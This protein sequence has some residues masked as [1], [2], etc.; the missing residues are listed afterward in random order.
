MVPAKLMGEG[1]RS[2]LKVF[3]NNFAKLSLVRTLALLFAGVIV[4]VL[5]IAVI[6]TD[7]IQTESI[8]DIAFNESERASEM[9]FQTLYSAMKRGA[10]RYELLEIVK[11]LN[12]II[13]TMETKLWRTN[14]IDKQFGPI[15]GISL[16]TLKAPDP[17]LLEIS[18]TAKEKLI[19]EEDKM[20]FL[21][22]LIVRKE[23]QSCHS[24]ASVGAVN[25]IID[26]RI[27]TAVLQRPMDRAIWTTAGLFCALMI[28]IFA[29]LYLALKYLVI[30]P[31]ARLTQQMEAALEI[32]RQ[33]KELEAFKSPL[34][35]LQ[36]MADAFQGLMTRVE[37]SHAALLLQ[38]HEDPLTGLANRRRLDSVLDLEI[39]RSERH[40]H[41][42]GL[43]M[44]D[45]DSFKPINDSFGHAA[46]D[47]V[48]HEVARTLQV[49]SRTTDLPA[50]LG[51]DEFMILVP[52]V[53][54]DEGAII[55]EKFSTLLNNMTVHYGDQ[56]I[57][58]L[59]SVGFVHY[60][61]H[62]ISAGE[63]YRV[64]DQRMYET[65]AKR[66]KSKKAADRET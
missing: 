66:K 7:Y 58:V 24:E 9:I 54:L 46:G 17:A 33:P 30:R 19:H 32:G 29:A 38:S 51:G 14:I 28:L 40:G 45:L 25:G 13:P 39:A 11:S 31:T 23:C 4:F 16:S 18:K 36:V 15:D 8:D 57:F 20:R 59:A 35:E 34:Y 49:N 5:V 52:E 50:R 60:P 37:E 10:S 48:L 64:A 47:E 12:G 22:P 44:I 56:A 65:K 1:D 6:I 3:R 53:S 21:Y 62:A 26:I 43:I 61:E 63:L 42:F 2:I 41:G 55:A 27:E